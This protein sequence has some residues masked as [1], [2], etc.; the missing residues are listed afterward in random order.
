[1]GALTAPPSTVPVE[2]PSTASTAEVSWI[3]R[4]FN[5]PE[6]FQP[7]QAA[8]S[9]FLSCPFVE[10]FSYLFG[11]TA[12]GKWLAQQVDPWIKPSIMDYRIARVTCRE[13]HLDP[14][15]QALRM[16]GDISPVQAIRQ[17]NVGKKKIDAARR[18][19]KSDCGSCIRRFENLISEVTK[20]AG[21]VRAQIVVIFHDEDGLIAL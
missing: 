16:I 21:R 18:L 5:E 9:R 6:P 20:H 13:Q 12:K 17:Y 1:M 19:E 8:S 4:P 14:R 15:V 10:N 11:Q 7:E 3:I 2:E